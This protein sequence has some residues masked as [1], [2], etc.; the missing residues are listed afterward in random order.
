MAEQN[1]TTAPAPSDA[2]T[3]VDPSKTKPAEEIADLKGKGKA[4]AQDVSMEDDDDDDDEEEEEEVSTSIALTQC[5][6]L[7]LTIV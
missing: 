3:A 7:I 5:F 6:W 1:G 4:P 2:I